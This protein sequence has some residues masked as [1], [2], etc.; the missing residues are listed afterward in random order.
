MIRRAA[1]TDVE[2]LERR[3][4]KKVSDYH[5]QARWRTPSSATRPSLATAFA[6]VAPVVET[7]RRA[8]RAGS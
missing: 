8:L 6:P 7:S 5:R 1:I 4:W 2:A 3:Q